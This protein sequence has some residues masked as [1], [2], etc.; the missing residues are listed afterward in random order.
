MLGERWFLNADIRYISIETK[1]K[2]TL[3]EL[4]DPNSPTFFPGGQVK[5]D[6]DINPWVY[7]L[8]VGWKF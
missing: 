8:N 1:A 7:G 6:V 4:G 5:R 3:P 2:I